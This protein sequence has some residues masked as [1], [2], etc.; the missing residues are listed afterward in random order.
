MRGVGHVAERWLGEIVE[1]DSAG[2]VARFWL[3]HLGLARHERERAGH[4]RQ[5]GGVRRQTR[6]RFV[7]AHRRRLVSSRER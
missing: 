4:Y 7:G 6:A 3:V 1:A 2:I 5:N